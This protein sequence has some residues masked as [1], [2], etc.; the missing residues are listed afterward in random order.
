VWLKVQAS[1]L[2]QV[3]ALERHIPIAMVLMVQAMLPEEV[4]AGVAALVE[5]AMVGSLAVEALDRDLV[6]VDTLKFRFRT[7]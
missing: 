4:P 6:V 2:A 7:N 3:L 5:A 1:E